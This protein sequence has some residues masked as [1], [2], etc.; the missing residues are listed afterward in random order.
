VLHL[1]HVDREL[2]HGEG[3]QVRMRNDVG[4][5]PVHEQF[6]RGHAEQFVGGNA[7]VGAADP[8]VFR[9]LLRGQVLEEARVLLDHR[10]RPFAVAFEQ[11]FCRQASGG[12]C[13]VVLL[14]AGGAGQPVMFGD[15][16]YCKRRASK[17][18]R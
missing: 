4:D 16:P 8:E 1:Q 17:R 13:H 3:V 15:F 10:G 12:F 5:V 2:Q 7:A 6:A 18:A 9:G 11:V 14:A